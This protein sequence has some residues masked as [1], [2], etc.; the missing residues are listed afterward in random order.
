MGVANGRRPQLEGDVGIVLFLDQ[1]RGR[2]RH[3]RGGPHAAPEHAA[4]GEGD[5]AG[6]AAP[7]SGSASPGP[8]GAP[9][10][11]R[12]RLRHGGPRRLSSPPP[13]EP[14]DC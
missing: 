12:P 8:D 5:G 14:G 10:D 13:P 2:P 11:E 6:H 1:R 9:D 4:V 3:D 7:Q